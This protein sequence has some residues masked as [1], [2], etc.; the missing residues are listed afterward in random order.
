MESIKLLTT[1][2]KLIE[3]WLD[4]CGIKNKTIIPMPGDAGFRRYFRV[5]TNDKSYIMMDASLGAESLMAFIYIADALRM[6][7]ICAPE[8]FFKDIEQGFL[9]I[10]DFGDKSYL[11]VLNY[12]NAKRYYQHA[13][14]TLAK[15]QSIQ[16]IP[17]YSLPHFTFDFMLTEWLWH[18]EWFLTKFL[19]LTYDKKIEDEYKKIIEVVAKQP[20]V[21]MHRDYHSA[22]LMVVKNEVGVLDFQDAFIGPV[23]YDLVSLL[24]DCYID[25]PIDWVKMWVENYYFFLIDEKRIPIVSK[26]CFH[27]WFDMMGLQRHLKALMT[28]ARKFVRDNNPFY[29]SFI[30]RTLNYIIQESRG[31]VHLKNLAAYYEYVVLP[32]FLKKVDICEQ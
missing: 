20:S 27:F 4:T 24:R 26:D 2:I 17:N 21:F 6:N 7:K 8:I 12:T 5:K 9:L 31:H 15:L 3:T 16:V 29:L 11:K 25:W 22:N 13:I 14:T 30:P 32:A 1:R 23:T 18:K 10:S 19:R 28:F